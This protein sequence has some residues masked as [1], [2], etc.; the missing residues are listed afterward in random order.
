L[1]HICVIIRRV[2]VN[3]IGKNIEGALA[4]WG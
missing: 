4:L 2:R 1:M 3:K